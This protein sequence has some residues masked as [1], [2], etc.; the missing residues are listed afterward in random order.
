MK[1]GTPDHRQLSISRRIAENVSVARARGHP[2]DAV[3]PVILPADVVVCTGGGHRGEDV[4]LAV[5]QRVQ[6]TARGRL[7]GHH[8][9]HLR[10][11]VLDDVTQ[12][13]DRVVELAPALDTEALGHGDLHAADKAPVPQWLQ[14]RIGEPQVQDVLH[15]QLPQEVVDPVEL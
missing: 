13:A 8:G 3:V 11:V 2:R 15:R 5:G 7:H 1:N 12:A 9:Q 10:Q 6:V 4:A 14:H